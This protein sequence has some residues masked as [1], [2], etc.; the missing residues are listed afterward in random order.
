LIDFGLLV[1]EEKIFFLK[2]FFVFLLFCYHLPFERGLP[3]SLIKLE[4]PSPKDD[5]CQVWLK[6]ALWFWR[7]FCDH[8]PFDEDLAFY[9]NKGLY[10][11]C[12]SVGPL[13]S[14]NL[15]LNEKL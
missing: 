4:F 14:Y 15:K 10:M 7:R 8:L 5:L 9:L 1:L 12:L 2:R 11:V 3:L 13:H 6:L